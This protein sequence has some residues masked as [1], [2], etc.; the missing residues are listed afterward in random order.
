LPN[1]SYSVTIPLVSHDTTAS[2]SHELEDLQSH[3]ISSLPLNL[4]QSVSVTDKRETTLIRIKSDY[5]D[6]VTI[7][8]VSKVSSLPFFLLTYLIHSF[9][10]LFIIYHAFKLNYIDIVKE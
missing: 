3:F 6:K 9:I 2:T 8:N 4:V 7:A 5:N 1:N 10:H